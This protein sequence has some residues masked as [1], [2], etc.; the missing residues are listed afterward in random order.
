MTQGKINLFY[1]S[2]PFFYLKQDPSDIKIEKPSNIRLQGQ[3]C[4]IKTFTVNQLEEYH[5]NSFGQSNW[6]YSC[7][8]NL[9][10]FCKLNKQT[11][12]TTAY[13][14]MMSLQSSIFHPTITINKK[15][16]NWNL[17]RHG[18]KIKKQFSNCRLKILWHNR[19]FIVAFSK[20]K[21]IMSEIFP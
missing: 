4:E 2:G 5:T 3:L 9:L 10:S 14:S 1:G 7:V 18:K 20:K 21:T 11:K 13:M 6:S 16:F 15:V 17:I 12:E 19:I 8:S